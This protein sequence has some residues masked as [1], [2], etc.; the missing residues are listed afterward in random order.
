MNHKIIICLFALLP[1]SLFAQGIE[2][3]HGSYDELLTKA[4]QENKPIF[5]DCYTT[6]CGPCKMMAAQTFTDP[7][8]GTYYNA[9]F[10]NAKIDMEKGEGT[11]IAAKF[12]IT[13][14]PTLVYL[15]PNGK[16]VSRSMGFK[17]SEEL[18]NLGKS[19]KGNKE[20]EY[21][22][23]Y[24]KG[25]RETGFLC[26]Y[27]EL[28]LN[29]GNQAEAKKVTADLV[30]NA[31]YTN[32]KVS[33][34]MLSTTTS[35]YDAGWEQ[36]V[37]NIPQLEKHFGEKPVKETFSY[38]A[39]MYGKK[40]CKKIQTS[41]NEQDCGEACLTSTAKNIKGNFG[42]YGKELA[43]NYL[44]KNYEQGKDTD[45]Y[46]KTANRYLRKYAKNN[47]E[48]N[49][50]H[51]WAVYEKTDDKKLLKKAAKW[52]SKSVDINSNYF[53]NDT[54]AA[55]QYKLGN[56]EKAKGFAEKA[57]NIAKSKGEKADETE[58]LLKKINEMSSK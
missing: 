33:E 28:L 47:W 44:V 22:D 19:I 3:F 39:A 46:V 14:Y 23:K 13:A 35:P 58:A 24:N 9:N 10:I 51:A 4:K 57:I 50:E 15:D 40:E 34:I 49:N 53:N 43:A 37:K 41:T 7:T 8:V 45:K 32:K 6:W 16:E 55:L 12:N 2:F 27:A 5:I 31:D 18:I 52:A 1:V 48:A 25:N 26:E 17:K 20:K 29:L 21:A 56:K 54:A 11:T 30:K 42:K 36:M 38:Y